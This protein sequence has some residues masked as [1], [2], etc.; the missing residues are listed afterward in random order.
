MIKKIQYII[1]KL[2][3]LC[4]DSK[5]FLL[6]L[7]KFNKQKVIIRII[8]PNIEISEVKKKNLSE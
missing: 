4:T 5:Y 6:I 3:S 1:K 8:N 7:K 2:G